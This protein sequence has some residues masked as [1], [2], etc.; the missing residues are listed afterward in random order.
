MN[1]K[2]SYKCINCNSS[3]IPEGKDY[4][5]KQ[6]AESNNSTQPPKGV[7][8]TIYN[9]PAI[10]GNYGGDFIFEKL[11][12]RDF[13]D[14]LPIQSID[15]FPKLRVGNTPLY[16][17]D[18]LNSKVLDFLLYLKDDSQNPSSSYK[19]RASAL[20]SAYAK[21]NNFNTI[22]ASSTGNAGSS[23]ACMA[24]ANKQNTIVVVP[25]KAP[26]A[27]LVQ[28]KMYGAVIIP[29]KA[30]YDDA[31]R[32]C[33]ELSDKFGF[34]NRNT[35][36]NPITIEGK[37]TAAFE[38]F[39]QLEN[40]SPDNVFVPTGDGVIISGIYK[41]F[42]DL[43]NLGI[44]THVPTIIS[45]QANG[46]SNINNNLDNPKFSWN[47]PNTFADSISVEIPANFY[48]ASG[49]IKKYN[50]IAVNVSDTEIREAVNLL[51]KQYGLFSEPAAATAFAGLMK[52]YN[53]NLIAKNS[54]NVVLLTGSGLKDINSVL[55]NLKLPEA[56][57]PNIDFASQLIAKSGL[58]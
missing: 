16:K 3:F 40:K 26:L 23:I 55:S 53:K 34:Y 28:I 48:M 19:D 30:S 57:S 46:S 49:F 33:N 10:A 22:I 6:C 1:N 2:F 52:L 21:E 58:I 47:K 24:A 12:E 37:K 31:F 56:V 8:K 38:I 51:A 17:V 44:I 29:V 42:E 14:I 5:C 13:I 11:A 27:K 15:S 45:V 20:V 43:L 18:S 25:A 32:L 39:S 4:L 35:A 41:G 54:S 7:L 36:Y 50:G 9:Y